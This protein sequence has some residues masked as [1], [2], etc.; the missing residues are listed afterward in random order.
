ML[1]ACSCFAGPILRVIGNISNRIVTKV[2]ELTLIVSCG[3][4]TSIKEEDSRHWVGGGA[5]QGRMSPLTNM[6][7]SKGLLRTGDQSKAGRNC[8]ST[9][10]TG[11]QDI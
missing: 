7:L 6:S 1:L 10:R 5:S 3:L 2:T 8:K 11:H 4:S 9:S